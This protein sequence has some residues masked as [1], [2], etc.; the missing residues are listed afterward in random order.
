[1][2]KILALLFLSTACFHVMAQ[3][4]KSS[5]KEIAATV[6]NQFVKGDFEQALLLF[7]SAAAKRFPKE[8]ISQ[9][10]KSITQQSG[11]YVKTNDVRENIE[12]N[13]SVVTQF[14]SFEKK[15]IDFRLVFSKK[16][17]IT[18]LALVPNHPVEHYKLPAYYDS[19]R[20]IEKEI[21]ITSGE[22]TLPGTL[23]LPVKGSKFPVVVLIHG[24]G[25][26]D[27]DETVGSTKMF[28]DVA[29][30]LATKGVAVLRYDKRSRVYTGRMASNRSRLTVKEETMDDA[31]AAV[32]FLKKYPAIDSSRI[33]LLGHAM[34]GMLL[35]R[36]ATQVK[37]VAGLFMVAANAGPLEDILYEQTQYIFTKDSLTERRKVMLD[38]LKSQRDKIKKLDA[39]SASDSTVKYLLSLPKSYWIDLNAYHQVEAVKETNIP[40]YILHGERDYQ[41]PMEDFNLWKKELTGKKNIQF[42]LYPKLNHLFQEGQG[43]SNPAEYDKT[44]N[45]PLYVIQ[46]IF[47]WMMPK[48]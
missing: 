36:I 1:M 14:L 33:F 7:D 28:K 18:S 48:K 10:W 40:V 6:L 11:V 23:S 22:L 37:G 17:K 15:N 5:R 13:F 43:K 8:K 31:V 44:G 45:V 19:T 46:D 26:N 16:D 42:K 38:S 21:K 25:P 41:V 27:R 29:L 3:D 4:K 34:G 12:A 24:S 20:V 32:Q 30:G 35:P 39:A 2:K 47:N 9:V